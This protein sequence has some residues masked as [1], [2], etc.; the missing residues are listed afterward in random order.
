MGKEE[1]DRTQHWEKIYNTK[2]VEDVS[3]YQSTP[4]T[5][6]EFIHKFNV[7]KNAKI[8]DVGGGNGFF[9]D[10]LLDLGYENITVLDISESAIEQAKERLGNKANRVNWIISDASTFIPTEHYD[11]W[12][13]RAALH[14]LTEDSE[15]NHYVQSV[16]KGVAEKGVLVIGTFSEKGPTK[17]SGI[18]IKQYSETS[19][20]DRFKNHFEKIECHTV[21]H[22]TPFDT[23]QNFVFCSFRKAQV[24][25]LTVMI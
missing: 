19:M 8:I 18:E 14:F 5:S 13:D 4:S 12:H 25:T 2:G 7:P 21:D 24:S 6:L 20:A 17:C 1:F 23:V 3:W 11:F 10:H 16:R 9:V 15:I 22:T